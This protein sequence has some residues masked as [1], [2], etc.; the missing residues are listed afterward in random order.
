MSAAKLAK[1]VLLEF[2]NSG[3]WKTLGRFDLDD[4]NQVAR[5][6][7]AA[8]VLVKT[9]NNGGPA[10]R[11]PTLRLRIEGLLDVLARWEL[12]CGWYDAQTGKPL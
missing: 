2:N 11:C 8:E 5:V 7:V 3:S 4:G 6:L 10:K 1:P 12:A 9:L